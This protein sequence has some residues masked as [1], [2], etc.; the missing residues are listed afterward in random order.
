MSTR[1]SV[2]RKLTI[3]VVGVGITSHVAIGVGGMEFAAGVPAT[4][5]APS[6]ICTVVAAKLSG[7]AIM[8]GFILVRRAIR[9]VCEPSSETWVSSPAALANDSFKENA[10]WAGAVAKGVGIED[11]AGEAGKSMNVF[12]TFVA[13]WVAA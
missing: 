7:M 2:W 1:D 4:Y 9:T 10:Q 12:F 8:D 5:E 6:R 13:G 11:A 3:G